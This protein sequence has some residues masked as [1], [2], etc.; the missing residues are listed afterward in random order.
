MNFL[1]NQIF[2]QIFV[3]KSYIE[4][5]SYRGSDKITVCL[6]VCLSSVYLSVWHFS[7]EL[8]ISFFLIF[9]MMVDNWN[10]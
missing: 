5:P 9:D 1:A 4:P 7:Q 8:L 3:L 10:I 6:S 2:H